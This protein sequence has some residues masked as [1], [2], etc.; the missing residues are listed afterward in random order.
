MGEESEQELREASGQWPK[1]EVAISSRGEIEW[2]M[3]EARCERGAVFQLSLKIKETLAGRLFLSKPEG[4]DYW[5]GMKI[6]WLM[7]FNNRHN[8]LY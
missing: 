1:E 5:G 8:R 2:V 4:S 7:V 6:S 3:G